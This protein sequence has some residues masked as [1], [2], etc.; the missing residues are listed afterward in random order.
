MDVVFRVDAS[1]LIGSGHVMR[2]LTLADEL[3]KQGNNTIFITRTHNGHLDNI[4]EARNHDKISL[5]LPSKRYQARRDDTVHA[6]WLG[7]PWY[8]DAKQ[9]GHAI[10]GLNPDWLVVD[11]Y[12]IDARWHLALRD[13]VRRI[14]VIDDLAD[15]EFDTDILLNQTYNYGENN[16]KGLISA[17]CE[18]LLGNQYALLRQEFAALRSR[19][20]NKRKHSDDIKHILVSLGGMDIDNITETVLASLNRVRWDRRPVIDVVLNSKAPNLKRVAQ[21]AEDSPLT[22][23]VSTDVEDMAERMLRA[24]LA[25]GAGGATSWERCCMGLP[26]LMMVLAENQ[27]ATANSLQ[28]IGAAI[29]VGQTKNNVES[30]IVDVID[31]ILSDRTCLKKMSEI[32][33][34][35][36]DG[37]GAKRVALVLN[38]PKAKDGKDVRLRTITPADEE[39]LYHWQLDP[40][41]RQYSYNPEVPSREEHTRWM[42]VKLREIEG[43]TSIIL[44]GSEPAGVIR[45]DL[46]SGVDR[47]TYLVSIYVAPH[48]YRLGLAMA[49]LKALEF[50]L[51]YAELRAEIHEEN[52]ASHK[53]FKKAGFKKDESLNAYVKYPQGCRQG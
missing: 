7:I 25:V 28:R 1:L 38:P 27:S 11:H 35:L 3:K 41:T 34:S 45:A 46:V 6:P 9:T 40:L 48:K 47:A 39:L 31:N 16:Y 12:G 8:I 53:L 32:S 42:K 21:I 18:T 24:D 10:G 4:I 14:F 5:P 36:I 23:K 15:R 2:C 26:T 43:V 51:D 17:K 29:L 44:H 20:I 37:L 33:F 30:E 13:K 19:A 22:V 50:I 49:A 52:I